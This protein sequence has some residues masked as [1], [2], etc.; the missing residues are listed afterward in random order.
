MLFSFCYLYFLEGDTLAEAQFVFS[1]G[2]TTYSILAGAIMLTLVLQFVQWLICQVFRFPR[3]YYALSYFPSLL[4][5]AMLT[6]LSWKA[7]QYYSFGKWIWLGPLLLAF[8]V[9]L[10]FLIRKTRRGDDDN[11]TRSLLWRNYLLLFLQLVGCGAVSNTKDT[12]SYELLTERF[13]MEQDYEA[14]TKVADRSLVTSRRLTELRMFALSKQGRL[15]DCLFDYPQ[16]D[17]AEGLLSIA[18]TSALHRFGPL[19][20]CY[21]LGA[22]PDKKT[23]H[24]AG[25]YLMVMNRVDSLRTAATQDYYLCYL[26]LDKNLRAFSENLKKYYR[27]DTTT[28]L[29]RAYREA[30][31]YI[32]N[33]YRKKMHPLD[34][35][36]DTE[37]AQRFS[38][39]IQRKAEIA[40][41][42][43]RINLT[44]REFGNTFWWYYEYQAKP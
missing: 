37:T 24:S 10:V 21:S 19:S 3:E 42:R 34:F 15:P 1:H 11:D 9:L 6:D 39:Y 44:R 17:G 2:L 41:E 32:N 25:Q 27:E 31:L 30:V 13:V 35:A 4:S 22:I 40:D 20:I 7:V 26:L 8:F 38:Q 43:E 16:Y 14:A 33:V 28:Y 36:I 29:P 5:L 12:Y 18:D 23:I